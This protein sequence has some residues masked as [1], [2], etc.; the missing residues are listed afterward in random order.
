MEVLLLGASAAAMS[1]HLFSYLCLNSRLREKVFY[2]FPLKLL[3]PLT[4][5]VLM[6]VYLFF[7][8]EL[9]VGRA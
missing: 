9:A 8:E 2:N 7:R 1:F 4:S 3:V 6:V 5:V